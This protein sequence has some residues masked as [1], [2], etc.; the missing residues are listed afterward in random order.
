MDALSRWT[1]SPTFQRYWPI[2]R[3]EFSK[4]FV[5]FCE[6]ALFVQPIPPR[7]VRYTAGGACNP[8][9]YGLSREF[10]LEF[11]AE[12]L[13][14]LDPTFPVGT[15]LAEFLCRWIAEV[16][17]RS[18]NPNQ[19]PLWFIG[20]GEAGQPILQNVWNPGGYACGVLLVRPLDP[21]RDELLLWLRGAH[22]SLGLGRATMDVFRAN[23]LGGRR[24][25]RQLVARY[26]VYGSSS[27]D[28]LQRALWMNF[29]NDLN[30]R[31]E[32]PLRPA[33]RLVELV[34]Q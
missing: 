12:V 23:I 24:P 27:G 10:G 9:A 28:R 17:A 8:A 33:D 3:A 15:P 4:S 6:R 19:V 16:V 5:R 22:R 32:R 21:S 30:F 29:F 26:P 14:V 34:W 2:L 20:L 13:R 31:Q 11:P 7:I 1:V 25:V 18:A